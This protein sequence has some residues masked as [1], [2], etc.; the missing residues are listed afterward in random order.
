VFG[1]IEGYG[2]VLIGSRGFR[3]MKARILGLTFADRTHE[4]VIAEVRV[5]YWSVPF[6]ATFQE[7][8]EAFPPHKEEVQ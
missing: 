8:V 5:N 3:C 2:E 7:M 4:D 1:A 6:F